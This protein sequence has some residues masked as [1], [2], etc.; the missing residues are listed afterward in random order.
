MPSAL[1][2]A[3]NQQDKAVKEMYYKEQ[4]KIQKQKEELAKEADF[5]RP[6]VKEK[7]WPLVKD[8][9]IFETETLCQLMAGKINEAFNGLVKKIKVSELELD[10]LFVEGNEMKTLDIVKDL[11]VEQAIKIIDG[12]NQA[13]GSCVRRE[14]RKRKMTELEELAKEFV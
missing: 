12:M 7:F 2:A 6:I 10:K 1:R 9:S 8:N 11:T 13:I 14:Q 3:K 5:L 4:E